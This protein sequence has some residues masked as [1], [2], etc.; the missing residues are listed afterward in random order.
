MSL[1]FSPISKPEPIFANGT[2]FCPGPKD[3]VDGRTVDTN[4]M[5]DKLEICLRNSM[6]MLAPTETQPCKTCPSMS[7]F[8]KGPS[9]DEFV[10]FLACFEG[11]HHA[12][13]SQLAACAAMSPLV[14]AALDTA[15][16][17]CY[18]K[19]DSRELL[20]AAENN[21]PER[22]NIT[23]FPR[24]TINGKVWQNGEVPKATLKDVICEAYSGP[25]LVCSGLRSVYL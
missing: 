8:G 14:K 10:S 7:A 5:T 21:R 12:N 13:E 16:K 20:W 17:D 15:Q 9:Q 23:H 11:V 4:C 25:S 24:V 2:M 22:S 3:K 19:P 1:D 6:L 18:A